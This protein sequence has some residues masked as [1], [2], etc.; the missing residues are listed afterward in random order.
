MTTLLQ[1]AIASKKLTKVQKAFTKEEHELIV[2]LLNNEISLTQ[3]KKALGIKSVT[4]VYVYSFRCLQ[5]YLD[6]NNIKI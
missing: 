6:K 3:V 5:H 1:K 4:S 2:A